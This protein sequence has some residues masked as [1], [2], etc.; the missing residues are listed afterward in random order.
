MRS[1]SFRQ[2]LVSQLD[3]S[4]RNAASGVDLI[5]RNECFSR[6]RLETCR[7]CSAVVRLDECVVLQ[8]NRKQ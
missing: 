6:T 8:L 7:A 2:R 3:R 5:G 4:I 1:D